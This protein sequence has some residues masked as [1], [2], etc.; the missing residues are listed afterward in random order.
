MTST[1]TVTAEPA[2]RYKTF[3]YRTAME[4]RGGRAGDV[5]SEGKPTFR[6][7]SPPEFKGE[8]GVWTPEDLLVAAVNAC[9][10]TTF[11]AFSQRLG[12]PVRSYA[13]DAEGV[14]EFTEGSYRFTGV[15]LRPRIVVSDPAAL[16]QVEKALADAHR[17]CIISNSILAKVVLEPAFEVLPLGAP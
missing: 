3:R 8:A 9:T 2:A 5:A 1:T 4:W 17:S 11:A 14:L 13:C 15:T 7:A 12:L 6:V 10:M 16:K